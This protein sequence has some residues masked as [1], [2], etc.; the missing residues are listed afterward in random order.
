CVGRVPSVAPGPLPT[1]LRGRRV[2]LRPLVLGDFEAWREVRQRNRD[3]LFRW[4]PKPPPGQPDDTESKPAF[5][6]RCGAR[7]R[8]WQ[9]G[10]GYGFGIFVDRRLCGEINLN[11]VQ[12]GPFQNAYVGYWIDKGCAG[13]GYVPEAL[14]VLAR[15]A[16]EDLRLHRLQVAIIPR[17]TAS[18]RVVEKL[19]LRCEGTAERYLEINGVWEDHL[20]FAI[21]AEE[22][23]QRRRDLLREWVGP[24]PA[25]EADARTLLTLLTLRTVW[26]AHH[27]AKHV[28]IVA[29]L[30]DQ[31]NLALADPDGV[32]DLIVS[33]ALSSLLMAQLA[34]R[35]DLEAVFDDLFDAE[36]AVLEMCPA[37]ELTGP[38]P[39]PFGAVVA[40]GSAAGASVFG[41]RSGASGKV[42]LNPP[43]SEMLNLG[44]DDHVVMLSGRR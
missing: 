16:F 11:N 10:T 7:E 38:G 22:W 40:A 20:R 2:V 4:E 27:G 37:G 33:N 32:D 26:P 24:A 13:N 30:L 18:R 36:G 34:Q 19:G 41:Y 8:E 1:E 39:L 43:K 23:R 9:L 44:P 29:E 28:R 3:W 14:V 21:T 6:A 35:A 31:R 12:R 17:N 5:N 15:F 25:D 42:V